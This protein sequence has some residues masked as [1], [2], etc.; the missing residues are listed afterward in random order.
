MAEWTACLRAEFATFHDY[1]FPFKSET[2]VH[3]A[4]TNLSAPMCPEKFQIFHAT[5]R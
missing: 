4:G 3:Y 2:L 5:L 1:V